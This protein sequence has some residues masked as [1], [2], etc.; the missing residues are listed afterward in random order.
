MVIDDIIS[1]TKVKH[2]NCAISKEGVIIFACLHLIWAHYMLYYLYAKVQP[3][4]ISISVSILEILQNFRK[5]RK[6][7]KNC[8]N[9]RVFYFTCHYI[10]S[11][12]NHMIMGLFKIQDDDI[13]HIL[14]SDYYLFYVIY[15]RS[16]FLKLSKIWI[17]FL[18]HLVTQP[19]L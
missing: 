12:P 1:I 13:L 14:V 11:Y 15:G 5:I 3:I 8:P 10:N 19:F 9:D 6:G 17:V 18:A 7:Q 16:I 2:I 4:S